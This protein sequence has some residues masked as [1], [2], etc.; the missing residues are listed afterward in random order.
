MIA[1]LTRLWIVAQAEDKPIKDLSPK[2]QELVVGAIAFAVVFVFMSKWVIP[3]VNKLLEDRRGRIQGDLEKA[4]EAKT[5]GQQM[6][7]DY[8]QQLAG[9]RDE[10]N[11]IIEE[12]R[13]TAEA[14]RRDMTG[15]AEQEYQAILGRA[16]DE[17]RGERD[18][19]FQ[20]LKSQVGQLSLALAERVVRETLDKERQLR[21]VDEYIEELAGLGRSAGNGSRDGGES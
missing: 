9:A 13:R 17:I 21:L 18:R 8:R 5:E 4:E 11:R 12:A 20:E 14:M 6:L 7:A 15:K 3:R 16:Q 19:V 1:V 10:A 2:L